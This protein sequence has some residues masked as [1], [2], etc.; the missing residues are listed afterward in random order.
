[1]KIKYSSIVIN[2]LIVILMAV[3]FDS[4]GQED[5]SIYGVV[6][7]HSDNKKIPN[8]DIIVFENGKRAFSK[9]TNLNGKYDFVL[10]FNKSYKI[11]YIYP[12][13]VTKYLTIN[14]TDV[15]DIDRIGGF[16]MNIDMTLFKE[17]EGLDV[18]ILKD[19]IGKAQFDAG[20]GEMAWDMAYTNMMQRRIRELMRKHDEKIQEEE[21]RIEKVRD[22]FDNLV[23]LGDA[24]VK[25]KKFDNAVGYY[26]EALFIIPSDEIVIQKLA[27]AKASAADQAAI[28]ERK[29][30]Y[31]QFV[32][33]GDSYFNRKEWSNAL[34]SFKSANEIF[35]DE[36]Y[37]R[38]KIEDINKKLED[39]RNQAMIAAQVMALLMEGDKLVAIE[40]FDDGISKY[41]EVLTLEA[42]NEEA[43]RKLAEAKIKRDA[44][45]KNQK[46][47]AQYVEYI[48]HADEDFNQK[49]YEAAVKNYR[50]ASNLKPGE[51]YPPEQ[52]NK[53]EEFMS[54]AMA[55]EARKK[56]FEELVIKGDSKVSE[57]EYESGISFY[58]QA[59]DIIPEDEAVE[60]KIKNAEDALAAML[61]SEEAARQ[62]KDIDDRFAGFVQ[63]GDNSFSMTDYIDAIG[64]YE[65]ALEV[66]PAEPDV[67]AKI[68]KSRK[69]M[70]D[71]LA[72][73]QVDEQYAETIRK[74]D[75]DFNSFKYD[76]AREYY[77]QASA[78]KP[79]ED[80][81]KNKM[82]EIDAILAKIAA[83]DEA[84]RLKD[85]EAQAESE[86]QLRFKELESEGDKAV[87]QADYSQGVGKYTEALLIFSDNQRVIDKKNNAE[88]LMAEANSK[89]DL[90][91]QYNQLIANAD[92]EFN[93]QNYKNARGI[94]QQAINV[95]AEEQYPKNRIDEIDL[96]L[97]ELAKNKEGAEKTAR[98][99]AL[100]AEG[101]ANVTASEYLNA[102]DKFE[103]A[104]E[105]FPNNNRVQQKIVN[106]RKM[107]D[108]AS[109]ERE[110]DDLY[111]DFV[112]KADGQ[113]NSKEYKEAK[114][115]YQ[116]AFSLKQLDYPKNRIAE[117]DKILLGI[118]RKK[119]ED[120]AARLA[121]MQNK[122]KDRSWEENISDEEKYIIAARNAQK[123]NEDLKYAELL[124]YKESLKRTRDGYVVKGENIR[125]SNA[126][127]INEQ[128][129]I[130][131]YLYDQ[132][133]K[134]DDLRRIAEVA[135][136]K[137][138]D[139]IW[140][141]EKNAEQRERATSGTM[142]AD[143]QQ[144]QKNL[145]SKHREVI[146]GNYNESQQ[147]VEMRYKKFGEYE[148]IRLKNIEEVENKKEDLKTFIRSNSE[149]QQQ[150]IEAS[151]EYISDIRKTQ[152]QNYNK[153]EELANTNYSNLQ[154]E[155][156]LRKME[157][158]VWKDKSQIKRE[159][160]LEEI[161]HTKWPG[162][163]DPYDYV[164]TDK[165]RSYKQG[166]T[167]ETFDEG[168]N[169]VIR[170]MVVKGNKVDEYKMVVTNH[171]TY[172]FKNG[173]S[174]TKSTWNTSTENVNNSD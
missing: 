73:K 10:E 142:T 46:M 113:F 12:Y 36:S 148:D 109:S 169:K 19:P 29:A 126:S 30:N 53:A 84:K 50:N 121:E 85:L 130:N 56:S 94:Y 34:T 1:M 103:L 122:N 90:D 28:K 11:E 97:L 120:E 105:I 82:I 157:T 79:K 112:T 27:D 37:P 66:K 75:K 44:W 137:E 136:V 6:R 64:F 96:L 93:D 145:D 111:N 106:A 98:F 119:A 58:N 72:S 104:L 65:K 170:R 156:E 62:Q 74:A 162:E 51:N 100:E 76:P 92:V 23:R 69:A 159:L 59:L 129:N 161:N 154:S 108:S 127:V 139:V 134:E 99:D 70:N 110:L 33:Q 153:G 71:L 40:E 83:D 168:N 128:K 172:Y 20:K 77:L 87:T 35:P 146:I 150:R 22:N 123:D 2:L 101:D 42:N 26:T 43:K 143:Y 149:S 80:Y 160:E 39:E 91:D 88:R 138:M 41:E 67:E 14:A 174:I 155:T 63:D 18:S 158:E 60:L 24:G 114:R 135:M 81:P 165:S 55:E 152:N 131:D 173:K 21:D 86:K 147:L 38:V 13:Y 118:E 151:S 132:I 102:I 124:A 15:P 164:E 68:A 49:N 141:K 61:A 47:D 163:K 8:V 4:F 89:K 52:I 167:E 25:N 140:T 45:L 95:K 115:N 54:L 78:L 166:I 48:A 3:T 5:I 16:E 9:K 133:K 31:D 17:I 171:G 57:K 144:Y 7:D 117:I 32:G 125:N 116:Q 107:F